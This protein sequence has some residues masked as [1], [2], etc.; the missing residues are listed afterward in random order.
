[1]WILWT[2]QRYRLGMQSVISPTYYARHLSNLYGC[3]PALFPA[4]ISKICPWNCDMHNNLCFLL[5]LYH[6]FVRLDSWNI[7]LLLDVYL[8]EMG[9]MW[10]DILLGRFWT[11]SSGLKVIRSALGWFTWTTNMGYLGTQSRPLIGSC[12]FWKARME[13][14]GR[15]SS[16]F[17]TFSFCYISF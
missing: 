17:Y 10:E 2:R 12:G 8:T 4:K 13:R 7:K 14:A 15:T 3:I 11:T 5:C 16:R 1:M 6:H 9:R